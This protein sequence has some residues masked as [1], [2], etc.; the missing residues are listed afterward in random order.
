MVVS[1]VLSILSSRAQQPESV[2]QVQSP[3]TA[4]SS[5]PQPILPGA[6]TGTPATGTDT[7]T[8]DPGEPGR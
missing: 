5:A 3:A 4:P 1:L 6:A 7:G 2:I 8:P